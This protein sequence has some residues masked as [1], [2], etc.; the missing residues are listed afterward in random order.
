MVNACVKGDKSVLTPIKPSILDA[1]GTD[2]RPA[3]LWSDDIR[4]ASFLRIWQAFGRS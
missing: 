3:S 1:G 4:P 2:V